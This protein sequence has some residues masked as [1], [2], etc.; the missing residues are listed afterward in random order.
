MMSSFMVNTQDK[1]IIDASFFVA[2]G[3]FNDTHNEIAKKI[4]KEAIVDKPFITT[5]QYLVSETLTMILIR[6]KQLDIVKEAKK[7]IFEKFKDIIH[8]EYFNKVGMDDIYSLFLNQQKYKSEFLSF[9]D[10]SLIIQAR[11]QKIKTIFTFDSTF[12]QFNRELRI[13]GI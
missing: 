2:L 13:M 5:N 8:I 11:K 1:I 4:F 3:Y 9:A 7:N 12:K 6:S 10:C